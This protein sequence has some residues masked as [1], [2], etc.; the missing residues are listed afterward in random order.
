MSESQESHPTY[1][2]FMALSSNDF[3]LSLLG[4][5]ARLFSAIQIFT[6]QG[7][8]DAN[9]KLID[10]DPRGFPQPA[11]RDLNDM[12]QAALDRGFDD[13]FLARYA[14]PNRSLPETIGDVK[15]IAARLYLLSLK[16][17]G[18]EV[19]E[20]AAERYYRNQPVEQLIREIGIADDYREMS[21]AQKSLA[22]AN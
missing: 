14:G 2:Q 1:S 7:H 9:Y 20:N 15:V 11:Q 16:A 21:G 8:G 22:V 17:R 13:E 6:V 19:M 10:G 5:A 12:A 18:V 4:S 3:G